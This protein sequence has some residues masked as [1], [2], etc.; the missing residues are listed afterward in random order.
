M[1]IIIHI[2]FVYTVGLHPASGDWS[3]HRVSYYISVHMLLLSASFDHDTEHALTMHVHSRKHGYTPIQIHTHGSCFTD[4]HPYRYTPMVRASQ[5]YTH[6]NTHSWFVL[7]RYTIIQTH[8]HTNTHPWFVHHRYTPI[9]IHTH[10]SCF[11][12]Q[13]HTTPKRWPFW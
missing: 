11:R 8:T 6:T 7:H 13:E 12:K 1:S 2:V 9:Q 3:W 10:G 4:T 5:I